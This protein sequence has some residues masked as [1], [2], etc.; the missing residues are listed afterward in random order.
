MAVAIPFIGAAGLGYVA[1]Y[2]LLGVTG[3]LTSE[4]LHGRV[5]ASERATMLSV[6]SLALQAGGVV[7][8]LL[9]GS[10]VVATTAGAGFAVI[11]AA[12]VAS[13][14]L[15]IGIADRPSAASDVVAPH[16]AAEAA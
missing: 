7:S 8:N 4:L 10:L 11:A 13:G 5:A 1:I 16:S 9:L 12:L 3:P 6:E 2:L 15:L 14:A